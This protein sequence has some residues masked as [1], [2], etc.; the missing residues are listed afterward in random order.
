MNTLA[1]RCMDILRSPKGCGAWY[2][3]SGAITLTWI[4]IEAIRTVA[5]DH[6]S[7]Q[8]VWFIAALVV[9]VMCLL[10]RPRVVG[11]GAYALL[12]VTLLLLGFLLIPGLPSAVVPR[13]RGT[14]AWLDLQVMHFQPSELAK[15]TFILAM[16]WYLRFRRTYRQWRGLLIPLGLMLLP[17]GLIVRQPDLGTAMIFAPTLLV[18]LIAAGARLWHIGTLVGVG[19]IATVLI[20]LMIYFAPNVADQILRPHQQDRFRG[21]ISQIQG[22]GRYDNSISFQQVKSVQLIG[23]GQVFGMGAEKTAK[24]IRWHGLPEARN[25]MIFTVIVARWGLIGAFLVF[26]LYLLIIVSMSF[27]AGRSKDPFVRLAVV[28]FG[29]VVFSQASINIAV[30]IGLL[31]VTGITLPF[32]SYG[33]S[34]LVIMFA[35]I[36]LTINFASLRPPIVSRPSFEFDP[37]ATVGS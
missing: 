9:M 25:D 4:G 35:M 11:L 32:V 3:L 31:P 18:M 26:I 24:L 37:P 16:A 36:G 20:V 14:T 10:P 17:V 2:A 1:N 29:G 7:K 5:P 28:G 34:S 30:A 33:G 21:M 23:A 15:L 13:G 27:V 8:I 12:I 6:A 19:T 22:D